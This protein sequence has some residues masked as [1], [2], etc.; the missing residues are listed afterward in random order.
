M[1]M[2]DTT[3]FQS[4]YKIVIMLIAVVAWK[5]LLTS[6]AESLKR[7]GGKWSSVLDEVVA[8]II[9]LACLVIFIQMQ[10]SQVI[11]FLVKPIQWLGGLIIEFMRTMGMPV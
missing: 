11:G 6:A 3:L 8:A 5:G 9:V 1:E 2:L 4:F 7:T 10:P